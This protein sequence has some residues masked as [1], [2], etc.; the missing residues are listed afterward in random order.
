MPPFGLRSTPR[1]HPGA[2]LLVVG[3]GRDRDALEASVRHHLPTGFV[4]FAGSVPHR[5]VPAYFAKADVALNYL[6][7]DEANAYR[8]SI[9]LR[10]ALA[11]GVPVVTSRTTDAERFAD[12]VRFPAGPGAAAFGE[13]VM[14]ELAVPDRTRT[15]AGQRWIAEHGTHDAAIRRILEIWREEG[16]A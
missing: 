1:A 12:W 8:A 11:A 4:V 7:D 2:R 3:D 9:K 5:D 14:A 13:A 10:E 16:A 15:A 6:E